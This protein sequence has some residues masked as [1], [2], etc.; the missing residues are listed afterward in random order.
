MKPVI[1]DAE[2]HRFIQIKQHKTTATV[3]ATAAAAAAGDA[4]HLGQ[5]D[6]ATPYG[7]RDNEANANSQKRDEN[8]SYQGGRG[9]GQGQGQ[10]QGRGRGRGQM[11]KRGGGGGGSGQGHDRGR[12]VNQ[13][14]GRD[15]P[16]EKMKM[17]ESLQ[18]N[19][20]ELKSEGG[21][22]KAKKYNSLQNADETLALDNATGAEAYSKEK[23]WQTTVIP[24]GHGDNK[25]NEKQRSKQ[26]LRE[27]EK[28]RDNLFFSKMIPNDKLEQSLKQTYRPNEEDKQRDATTTTTATM[29][30][31]HSQG[32]LQMPSSTG[33]GNKWI[34]E[35]EKG[36][37]KRRV[38][39]D[40]D[41]SANETKIKP[42]LSYPHPHH[43]RDITK[44]WPTK[45]K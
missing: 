36:E 35:I 22:S 24:Q 5:F 9:R 42:P 19:R 28:D 43:N 32:P 33:I 41:F 11:Q 29:T 15:R 39:V 38:G 45:T 30:R 17:M 2:R 16:L 1:G 14:N 20:Q 31:D 18:D 8:T 12:P 3:A 34:T 44:E 25:S 6:N 37:H 13:R 27:K 40:R 26:R 4:S 7:E 21:K 23:V 10:G